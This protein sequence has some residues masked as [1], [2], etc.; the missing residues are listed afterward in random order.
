MN[1]IIYNIKSISKTFYQRYNKII[2]GAGNILVQIVGIV[3]F[4][5]IQLFFGLII[6]FVLGIIFPAL[7]FIFAL[8]MIYYSVKFF[9]SYRVIVRIEPRKPSSP[10]ITPLTSIIEGPANPPLNS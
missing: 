2:I 7:G 1:K 5:L 9:R 8:I 10:M 3:L 6:S 4:Y